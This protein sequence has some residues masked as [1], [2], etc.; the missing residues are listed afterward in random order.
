M[1]ANTND[2]SDY[3]RY[4]ISCR[5]KRGVPYLPN[6]SDFF[7]LFKADILPVSALLFVPKPQNG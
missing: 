6:E 3:R 4:H 2:L 5:H 1:R 7:S